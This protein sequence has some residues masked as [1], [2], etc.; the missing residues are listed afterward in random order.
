VPARAPELD[1]TP[2]ANPESGTPGGLLAGRGERVL[3]KYMKEQAEERLCCY[4]AN[5]RLTFSDPRARIDC[6]Q[7]VE[8]AVF[9]ERMKEQVE[10]RLRFYDDGVA[11]TKN[12]TAMQARPRARAEA[13]FC[14]R[15]FAQCPA[16]AARLSWC[17]ARAGRGVWSVHECSSVRAPHVLCL[18]RMAQADRQGPHHQSPSF[19]TYLV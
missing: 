2:H 11:P 14:V 16:V 6:F 12:V 7:D 3:G 10:E 19:H 5:P 17:G 8:T 9:G 13:P 15:G 18:N 1:R 4:A